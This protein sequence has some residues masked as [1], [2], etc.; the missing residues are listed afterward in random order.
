MKYGPS[1]LNS[2]MDKLVKLT[3][4]LHEEKDLDW[5]FSQ[6]TQEV[7]DQMVYMRAMWD[8]TAS[9]YLW[10]RYAIPF[11]DDTA[12][13]IPEKKQTIQK[14][15]DL[16]TNSNVL[17]ENCLKVQ[18]LS[19]EIGELLKEADNEQTNSAHSL[20]DGQKF[21]DNVVRVAPSVDNGYAQWDNDSAQFNSLYHNR[22]S[23]YRT[24]GSLK[25]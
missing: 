13:I 22:Q 18:E 15:E 10:K 9:R 20:A 6:K 4:L 23:I 19:E 21:Y 24:L 5:M 17:F 16:S 1:Q 14:T 11:E 2:A 25:I 12:K 8:D 7:L 3:T